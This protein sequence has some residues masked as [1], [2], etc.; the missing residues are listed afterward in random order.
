MMSQSVVK[1]DFNI[2]MHS[3]SRSIVS[4]YNQFFEMLWSQDELYKNQN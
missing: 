2:T 4:I 1:S 3:N